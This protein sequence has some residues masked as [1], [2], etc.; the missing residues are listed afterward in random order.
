MK[1]LSFVYINYNL[2]KN[3]WDSSIYFILR[4]IAIFSKQNK[5]RVF[6]FFVDSFWTLTTPKRKQ[7]RQFHLFYFASYCHRL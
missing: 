6:I 7:L 2:A 3:C 4:H 1:A 5:A